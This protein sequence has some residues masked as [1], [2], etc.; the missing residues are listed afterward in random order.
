MNIR[1]YHTDMSGLQHFDPSPIHNMQEAQ[2]Y[3]EFM[4]KRFGNPP[5]RLKVDGIIV[6]QRRD[7][8][9]PSIIYC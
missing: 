7:F 6:R 3:I 9:K 8:N 1:I 5:Y 2:S 4:D